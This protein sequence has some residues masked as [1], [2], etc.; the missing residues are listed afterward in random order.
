MWD[1]YFGQWKEGKLKRLA[2]FG[3]DV[4]LMVMAFAVIMGVIMFFGG[5]ESS[6]GSSFD[7]MFAGMGIVTV[8]F[9]FIFLILLLVANLNIMAKRIRDMGLPAWGTVIGII[10]V[11]M[12]LGALFP[13]QQTKVSAIVADTQEGLSAA[14]D[15]HASTGSMVVDIFNLIV[16]AFL[17]FVPSDTF[18][19]KEIPSE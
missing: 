17:V 13:D 15:A 1:I 3:Y 8:L 11:S 12:I 18:G 16:F 10:I 6:M 9:V 7:E 19:K 2:Y 14:M 4:L 5:L